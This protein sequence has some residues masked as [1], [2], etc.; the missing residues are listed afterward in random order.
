[1]INN[2]LTFPSDCAIWKSSTS[3]GLPR[4]NGVFALMLLAQVVRIPRGPGRSV[5]A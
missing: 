2:L 4:P 5:R 1:M 3:N